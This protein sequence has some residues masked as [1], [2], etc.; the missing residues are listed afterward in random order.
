MA[1]HKEMPGSR[2]IQRID[3]LRQKRLTTGVLI[4]MCVRLSKKGEMVIFIAS[5]SRDPSVGPQTERTRQ[6]REM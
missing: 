2:K 4:I 6:P 1:L 5:N 3:E